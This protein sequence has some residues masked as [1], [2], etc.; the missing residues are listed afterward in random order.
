MNTWRAPVRKRLKRSTLNFAHTFLKDYCR[1]P[2]PCYELFIFYCNNSTSFESIFCMKTVKSRLFKKYL[3]RRKSRA[4]FCLSLGW[5]NQWEKK[6]TYRKS[7][8][9]DP[10]VG[11][12]TREPS[13]RTFH[14]GPGTRDFYVGPG[15]WDFRP[16]TL[17]LRPKTPDSICGNRDP[18][19]CG[20][21]T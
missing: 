9:W 2:C 1:K 15:T 10:Y 4:R 11:P 14:L 8:T 7:V 13:S 21:H 5:L 18:V 12:K 6:K 20:A 16:G 19:K 3:K 17:H